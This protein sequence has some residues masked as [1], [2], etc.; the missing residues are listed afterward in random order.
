LIDLLVGVPA[1]NIA[2]AFYLI[3]VKTVSEAFVLKRMLKGTNDDT[4][5]RT[6]L[7]S[8]SQSFIVALL[9]WTI[10]NDPFLLFRLSP[11]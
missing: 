6:I 4:R 10:L 11:Q 7:L 8:L 9:L 2:L 1:I 3:V 5:L